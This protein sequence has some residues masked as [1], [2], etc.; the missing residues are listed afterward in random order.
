MRSVSF[1]AFAVILLS[2]A[3]CRSSRSVEVTGSDSVRVEVVRE[4]RVVS[5]VS[6][7]LMEGVTLFVDTVEV[8][9]RDGRR[10]R[11]TGVSLQH[12]MTRRHTATMTTTGRDTVSTASSRSIVAS[13]NED[14]GVIAHSRGWLWGMAGLMLLAT[15]ILVRRR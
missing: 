1:L 13:G 8:T 5:A 10:V 11:M 14:R 12:D 3:S 2:M 15:I 9:H 7:S 4:V 6:D